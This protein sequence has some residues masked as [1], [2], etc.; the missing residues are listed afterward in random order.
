VHEVT[1]G[2][3]RSFVEATGHVTDAERCE[4]RNQPVE[5]TWRAPGFPQEA[6]HP[7]VW[8]SWNDAEAFCQW[9][10]AK[11]GRQVR[12]PTEAEWEYACRAG[13]NTAYCFGD[14]PELADRANC[15]S[16]TDPYCHRDFYWE[17]RHPFTSPVGDYPANPW[18]LRDMHGNASEWCADW[19]A[20]AYY[21]QS[22]AADPQG[23]PTGDNR[24]CR[25][26]SHALSPPFARSGNRVP[27]P[28]WFA[29]PGTG[30]RVAMTVEASD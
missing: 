5:G 16:C 11:E 1:V 18:G 28:D 14:L 24:V 19:Y 13:T 9:L 15:R 26:G 2:Q 7:A 3:F 17:D 12:L 25:G 6:D 4:W 23:P 27:Y 30:F 8:I 29:Q 10:S 22:P 20:P 21:R